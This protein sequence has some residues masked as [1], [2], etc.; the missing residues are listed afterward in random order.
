MREVFPCVYGSS[1]IK[2]EKGNAE[3]NL[4]VPYVNILLMCH[5]SICFTAKS[6]VEGIFYVGV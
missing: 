6:E 2:Y 5:F 4:N 1:L 3:E